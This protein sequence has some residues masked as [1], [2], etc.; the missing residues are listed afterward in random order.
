MID[1]RWPRPCRVWWPAWLLTAACSAPQAGLVDGVLH[2]PKVLRE[3]SGMVLADERTLACIQDE[4]GSLFF[5]DLRG[6]RP[7]LEAPFG[8]P[9]DYEGLAKVGDDYWVLR[10]D[11]LLLQIVQGARGWAIQASHR[12]L[13]AHREYEG[14]CFDAP[15]RVLLIL[16]KDLADEGQEAR[17]Q[18]GVQVFD[19]AT[20]TFAPEPRLVLRR[21][22]VQSQLEQFSVVLPP[23]V[24]SKGKE[25]PGLKLHCSE[26]LTVPGSDDLLILS[27]VDHLLARIGPDG[28]VRGARQLDAELL[29]QPEGMCF[30]GDGKLLVG[31]EGRKGRAVARIVEL[32]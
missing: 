18:V 21:S 14:L 8:P 19:L 25:R 31:S 26:L 23:R 13:L 28:T 10:S 1:L 7:V 24:T 9:G 29:P 17:S 20:G 4:V 22:V 15:R 12:L 5:V 30:L 16:P 11:G 6:E 3:V 32:P 27:A 2:L